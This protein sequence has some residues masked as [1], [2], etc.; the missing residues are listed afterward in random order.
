[1]GLFLFRIVF[2][3]IRS[4]LS[5]FCLRHSLIEI[6]NIINQKTISNQKT[7]PNHKPRGQRTTNSKNEQSLLFAIVHRTVHV[8]LDEQQTVSRILY[9]WTICS[10]TPD[11]TPHNQTLNLNM[12]CNMTSNM[13]LNLN[14]FCFLI[15]RFTIFSNLSK[16]CLKNVYV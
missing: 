14:Y 2:R 13:T 15:W 11:R 10:P 4:L 8:F 7:K 16:I 9:P 1:M 6:T 12:S 3:K 5:D